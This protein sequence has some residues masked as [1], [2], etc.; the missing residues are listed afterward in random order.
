M[1]SSPFAQCDFRDFS[2]WA[3]IQLLWAEGWKENC[4]WKGK[5]WRVPSTRRHSGKGAWE[6]PFPSVLPVREQLYRG[7]RRS[8]VLDVAP[9]TGCCHCPPPPECGGLLG[10]RPL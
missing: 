9:I 10:L 1:S 7:L 4:L 2:C 6:E 8:R 5:E 3:K